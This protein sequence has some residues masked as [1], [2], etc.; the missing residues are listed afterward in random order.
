[1]RIG[2]HLDIDSSCESKKFLPKNTWYSDSHLS[3][4]SMTDSDL[5]M[6]SEDCLSCSDTDDIFVQTTWKKYRKRV[7]TFCKLSK[8]S[9]LTETQ[10]TGIGDSHQDIW[11]HDHKFV[12]RDQKCALTE[13]CTSFEMKRM[14]TRM[15]QLVCIAK[16]TSS[17][18]HTRESE[19]GT[20]SSANALALSLKQFHA[21]P[22]RLY[23]K[24]T[25]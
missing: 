5:D 14:M 19:A 3:K 21:H 22:Y 1:M 13:D 11:G 6:T 2:Y 12:R 4:G 9:D 10:M 7:R 20:H 24:R 16:A 25:I 17:K 23:E 8:G 15:D 18:I